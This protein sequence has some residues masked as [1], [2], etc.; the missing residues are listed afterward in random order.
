MTRLPRISPGRVALGGGLLVLVIALVGLVSTVRRL[1]VVAPEGDY[2]VGRWHGPVA[3]PNGEPFAIVTWYPAVAETGSSGGYFPDRAE[4]IS[5]LVDS[6]QISRVEA[7]GLRFIRDSAREGAELARLDGGWP[8]LVLSP[9]NATNVEFYASIAEELASRGYVVVGINHPRQVPVT[10]L[11]SG[12]VPYEEVPLPPD[13]RDYAV[14]TGER[15]SARVADILALLDWLADSPAEFLAGALDL[16]AIGVFGHSLGGIAAAE[17]CAADDRIDA[18]ANLDGLQ[19]GGPYGMSEDV[20]PVAQP[21]MFVTKEEQLALDVEALLEA[22][23]DD[24]YRVV[25]VGAAHD[26]FT[27]AP[28][29][30]PMLLPWD[31][32][33]RD[34]LVAARRYL[35]AFFDR[36]LRGAAADVI[37]EV[38]APGH[39]RLVRYALL[40]SPSDGGRLRV[41]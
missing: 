26:Q 1:E 16:E 3:P 5:D 32:D 21:F 12:V 6:G 27:D 28:A 41:E 14:A 38:E 37:E 17:A 19:A 4:L 35:L 40:A 39:V 7:W 9:G 30:Q 34:T 13:P 18:C 25:L 29:F 33:A 15:V 8:V 10:V 31:N 22:G 24:T 23:G 36:Y 2:A 20:A 11:P